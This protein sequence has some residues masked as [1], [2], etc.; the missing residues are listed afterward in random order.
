M[1]CTNFVVRRGRRGY[2]KRRKSKL[3][4][5]L[6]YPSVIILRKWMLNALY[7]GRC[8]G[9]MTKSFKKNLT[10]EKC[11]P[12]KSKT[13]SIAWTTK[14][15]EGSMWRW[16]CPKIVCWLHARVQCF[17]CNYQSWALKSKSSKCFFST[18][19]LKS[20]EQEKKNV[21]HFI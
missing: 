20:V 11:S 15:L 16:W 21:F 19:G 17:E 2:T 3:W 9:L 4:I 13:N 1:I 14:S 8:I 7:V 6:I 12:K 5:R 18:R 10:F